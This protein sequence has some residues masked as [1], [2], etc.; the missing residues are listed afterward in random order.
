MDFQ[1]QIKENK[2]HAMT[3]GLN[4]IIISVSLLKQQP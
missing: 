2:G 3:R 1:I 4:P